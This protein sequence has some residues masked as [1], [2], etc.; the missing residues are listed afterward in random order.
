MIMGI[1]L[2][3]VNGDTITLSS[4]ELSTFTVLSRPFGFTFLRP[5]LYFVE[6]AADGGR[7]RFARR[8]MRELD[9]P[10][11]V[12]GADRGDV[13]QGLRQLSRMMH[14]KTGPLPR[15]IFRLDSG[16]RYELEVHLVASSE[17]DDVALE[18]ES[19]HLLTFRAPDPY[20]SAMD[21]VEIPAL[22]AASA[23]PFLPYLSRL[24]VGASQ[25]L[26]SVLVENPGDVSSPVVWVIKGPADSVSITRADGVGFGL[27]AISV[28]ETVTVDTRAKTVRDQAGANRY[29][30]LG[31]APKLFHVPGGSTV[32]GVQA[33]GATSATRV[34]GYFYPRI[35][36]VH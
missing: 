19:A 36:V 22:V 17:T 14:W 11:L 10:I 26:G 9:I 15:I 6:S 2:V 8:E 4:Y 31:P 21:A 33:V 1:D 13:E 27:D 5:D 23:D 24:Q 12:S 34:S 7:L 30:L 16:A 25:V 28:G 35:E 18:H 32:I 3:G 20:W 29:G